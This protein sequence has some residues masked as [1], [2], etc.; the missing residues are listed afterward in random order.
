MNF[1]RTGREQKRVRANVDL[2]P[3]IDVV[4]Q[5]LIFFMLS[6]TFV[7]QSRIEVNVPEA[8]STAALEPR[9][10]AVTLTYDEAG[11]Q[12]FLGPDEVANMDDLARQLENKLAAEP[13]LAVVIRA[14]GRVETQ[15]LVHVLDIAS[16]LG[17]EKPP[18]IA[19]R[20]SED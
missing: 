4:F 1:R 18:G 20:P 10:L 12:V 16:R 8:E 13:G 5:L 15:K 2:T 9:S 19:V 3:L 14:D 11:G 6:A 17:L 7:V